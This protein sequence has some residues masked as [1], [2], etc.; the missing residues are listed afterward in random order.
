MVGEALTRLTGLVDRLNGYTRQMFAAGPSPDLP[1]VLRPGIETTIVG[2]PLRVNALGLRGPETS[3]E[4]AP[5]TFRV[6][7]LG[8][9]VVFGQGVAEEATFPAVL[10]TRLAALRGTPVE[11][12]NAGVQGYDTVAEAAFLEGAG[13]ALAPQAVVVGMSLNDYDMAPGYDATGVLTRRAPGDAPPG[14]LARSEFLLLLRWLAAWSQGRLMTQ[15]L[16]RTAGEPPPAIGPDVAAAVDRAVAAEH[17]RFYHQPEPARWARVRDGLARMR[18]AAE[19]RGVPLVVAI[20]PESY[21]VGVAEPDTTPQRRI[22]A[23]CAEVGVRCVDLLPAF[24]AAGGALFQDAQHPNAQGLA[25][26]AE[27]T[28]AAFAH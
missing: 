22:L 15:V 4:P 21:Q 1:Y 6:L 28:A 3:R 26:A 14:I 24:S 18:A 25:I 12:L 10:A 19:A 9:S 27:T 8:D 20:F 23:L 5:G 2:I 17:L 13:A 16:S 7:V 11:A